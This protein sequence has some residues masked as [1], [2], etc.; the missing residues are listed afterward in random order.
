MTLVVQRDAEADVVEAFDWE[1][2]RRPGLGREFVAQIESA[3]ARLT[4]A[5]AALVVSSVARE[6]IF[7]SPQRAFPPDKWS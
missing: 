3:F 5:P 2:S 4:A 7:C 6:P 1:E